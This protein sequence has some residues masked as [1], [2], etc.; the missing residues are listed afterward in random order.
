MMHAKLQKLNLTN[1]SRFGIVSL[2]LSIFFV[3]GVVFAYTSPGKPTGF[4]NDFAKV[5]TEGQVG[6]LN[7]KL[8]EYKQT[9]GKEVSVVTI[10]SLEGDT[11]ENYANTLFREWGIGE[12]EKNNGVL[13][14]IAIADRKMRIE[15]GYGLEGDLTDLQTYRIQTDLIT[16]QFKEQK[17]FEGISAGVDGILS[18]L[19]G[20][21]P[22]NTPAEKSFS[23][24]KNFFGGFFVLFLFSVQFIFAILAP[25]K[26]WW[27]GGVLGGG[28]GVLIG[29][30][31]GSLIIGSVSIVSLILLGLLIDFIVS[32]AYAMR[33]STRNDFWRGEW[34]GG[35]FGGGG[36]GGGFGGFGGGSSGGG[37]SS[38][39]W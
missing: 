29:L 38:S 13:L 9:T 19:N 6:E 24:V 18:T 1:V 12:K 7:Q 2:F 37:G 10:Q 20:E 39:G 22:Q 34:G 17:Y 33:G 3:G 25:T 15:V 32:H 36:G 16:P 23:F 14:L 28:L 26:S 35:G 4:V 21:V 30:F 5:L 31:A 27:L 11:V 8:T